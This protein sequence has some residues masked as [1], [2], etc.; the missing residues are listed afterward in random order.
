MPRH[1]VGPVSANARRW[2]IRRGILAKVRAFRN[3]LN[4]EAGAIYLI[5]TIH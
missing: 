4:S 5:K 3:L 2:L 1:Y